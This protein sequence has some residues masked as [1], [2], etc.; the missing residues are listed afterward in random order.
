MKEAFSSVVSASNVAA[1]I[2]EPVL[3]EG[4]FIPAPK[5]YLEGLRE[6]CS[7]HGIMLI[8]DEVQ[9]GFGRTGYWGAY[10]HYGV[11]PDLSTWAKAMGGG[12]PIAAV[13]GKAEVMDAARPG[14]VGGTYGGNPVACASALATIDLIESQGLC[15]RAI[16]I[17]HK[18]RR[19]FESLKQKTSVVTDV[20]GIGAMMAME[21]SEDGDPR[22][23][24]S[25]LTRQVLSACLERGVLVIAAG[26]HGNVIRV[27]CPL[28]IED[29]DLAQALTVIG[30]ELMRC[31]L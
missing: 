13:L 23:P 24:A 3:G 7:E 8:F 15:A 9:T 16:E 25:A 19:A 18:V 22:L 2:V 20:R 28:V 6:L 4:G 26:T 12:L 31:V 27:L 14:T 10:Q 29:A 17:G 11:I 21:L 5:A 30:E 1:V